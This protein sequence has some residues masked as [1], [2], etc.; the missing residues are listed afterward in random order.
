MKI[1]ARLWKIHC[2]FESAKLFILPMHQMGLSMKLFVPLMNQMRLWKRKS[3]QMK[4]AFLCNS[5]ILSR[6]CRKPSMM[7]NG[8]FMEKM[9]LAN[10]SQRICRFC[11][12]QQ[13]VR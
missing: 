6:L 5:N 1:M 2:M 4:L 8:L 11:L 3:S 10:P 7:W 9:N 12:R 13:L